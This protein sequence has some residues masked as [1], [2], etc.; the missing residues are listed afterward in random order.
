MPELHARRSLRRLARAM[1]A[2]LVAGVALAAA[3]PSVVLAQAVGT[4][5]SGPTE[6]DGASAWINPASMAAGEGTHLELA[7]SLSMIDIEYAPDDG[8]APT[9]S[10]P[11]APLVTLGGFTS[12][13]H[14]DWRVGLT[15]GVPGTQGGQWSRDGGA[16][17]ITRYYV[18]EGAILQIELV[19]AVSFTPAPWISLGVG[20][21]LVYGRMSL[22][23]DKDLG[24]E[25]NHAI[26]STAVDSPFPYADPDLAA[27]VT[28]SADGFG[29][30]AIGGVLLRPIDEV[31][32][33]VGVH[34]RVSVQGNGSLS[35]EYPEAA[36][37]FV[38]DTLP[39]ATLPALG[40]TLEVPLDRPMVVL[41]GVSARPVDGLEL[42]LAY[43]F[44]H[45]S[46]DPNRDVYVTQ[47]IS[48]NVENAVKPQAYL[49]RHRVSLRVEY[50]PIPTLELA[51][52]GVY[53]SSTVPD[54]ALTPNNMDFAG[55][56]VGVAARWRIVE[57]FSVTLQL[58][59]TFLVDHVV[60]ESLH[61]PVAEPSLAA[62]NHPS[63]TGRY[64]GTVDAVRLALALDL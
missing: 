58:N 33:G 39:S 8:R 46:A 61:R 48:G 18:V 19:P 51:L 37:Q 4:G 50:A 6:A 53:Q 24:T 43:Q 27:P 54:L 34:S 62:F 45:T 25:I 64:S 47:A 9:R 20:V 35:V 28:G 32:L 30:G 1:L 59:H 63:P 60:T 13:L 26:G 44:E 31:S 16:S 29:V 56:S 14:P 57:S 21:N 52:L 38:A 2:A 17:A 3:A 5:F 40:G 7:G 42:A 10:A 36:R 41:A 12:A 23:V 11:L 49:N 55:I 15:L 22:E